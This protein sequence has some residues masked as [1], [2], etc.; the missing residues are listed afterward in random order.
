MYGIIAATGVIALIIGTVAI[1][2]DPNDNIINSLTEA[3]MDDVGLYYAMDTGNLIWSYGAL[4]IEMFILY[5]VVKLTKN[6]IPALFAYMS[7][8]IMSIYVIQWIFIGLATLIFDKITDVFV[9]LGMGAIVLV[10][11]LVSAWLW[12]KLMTKIKSG[13]KKETVKQK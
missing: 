8:H 9:C 7:K 11:T 6:K 5:L 12:D 2:R 3:N 10:L 13:E 1:N 4:A